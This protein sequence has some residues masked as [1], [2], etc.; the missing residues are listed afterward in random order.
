MLVWIRAN[1]LLLTSR[2]SVLSVTY[3]K[4]EMLDPMV[5]LFWFFK[6]PWQSH[7]VHFHHWSVQFSPSVVSDSLRPH[8]PQHTR[9]PC[10]SPTPGA[11]SNSCP[12]SWWCHPTISSSVVPFSSCPQSFPASGSF[13]VSQF[14]ASGGQ[15]IGVSASASASP[16]MVLAFNT[17][18]YI[19][20][21][22]ILLQSHWLWLPCSVTMA[23]LETQGWR[24]LL[25]WS[26]HCAKPI[27]NAYT[28]QSIIIHFELCYKR[29][30]LASKRSRLTGETVL[31]WMRTYRF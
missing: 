21:P 23:V 1:R 19:Q 4:V 27:I 22:K 11:C 17:L 5:I 13:P 15:S 9:P 18:F 12:L 29:K 14:F 24:C 30:E 31:I 20:P 6:K 2:L 8:G 3:P 28:I 25:L 10:P 26:L 16:S 7:I